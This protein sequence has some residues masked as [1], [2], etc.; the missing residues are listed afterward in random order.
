MIRR[1]ETFKGHSKMMVIYVGSTFLD[2][3]K[4]SADDPGCEAITAVSLEYWNGDERYTPEIF[5]KKGL[6]FLLMAENSIVGN[7]FPAELPLPA[8]KSKKF[9]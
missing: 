1:A 5:G 7:H 2:G 3:V 8:K 6:W 4:R 9:R